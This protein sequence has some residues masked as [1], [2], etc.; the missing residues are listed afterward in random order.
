M[1][2]AQRSSR[3]RA[4]C[5]ALRAASIATSASPSFSARCER[6]TSAVSSAEDPI[7]AR[8]PTPPDRPSPAHREQRVGQQLPGRCQRVTGDAHGAGD[9]GEPARGERIPADHAAERGHHDRHDLQIRL[10]V[11]GR[12]GIHDLD[13]RSGVAD[14]LGEGSADE[15]GLPEDGEK[16]HGVAAAP[17]RDQ[18]PQHM[19]EGCRA[20][21]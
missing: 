9:E 6:S 1:P 20:R 2:S 10:D 18:V 17:L 19:H 13:H 16:A 15:P 11:S 8:A 21:V 4:R 3:S 12:Q 5:Q 7:R 14:E